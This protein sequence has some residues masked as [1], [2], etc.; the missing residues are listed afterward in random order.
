MP[1]PFVPWP[2]LVSVLSGNRVVWGCGTSSD[3]SQEGHTGITLDEALGWGWPTFSLIPRWHWIY[4]SDCRMHLKHM[5]TSQRYIFLINQSMT[6]SGWSNDAETNTDR[7]FGPGWDYTSL[8]QSP[9]I[10]PALRHPMLVETYMLGE[11]SRAGFALLH[12]LFLVR[13]RGGGGG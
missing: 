3:P 1:S 11:W 13:H 5:Y 2:W 9:S 7:K 8:G 6:L 10:G 4:R 12:P